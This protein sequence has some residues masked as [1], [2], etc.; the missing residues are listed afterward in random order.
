[1]GY[2]NGVKSN[3]TN[4]LRNV[5]RIELVGDNRFMRSDHLVDPFAVVRFDKN[6]DLIKTR[7]DFCK[8]ELSPR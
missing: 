4:R 6:D 2:H 8:R 1:M 5:Y 7:L 3:G